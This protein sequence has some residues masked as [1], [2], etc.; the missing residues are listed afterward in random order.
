ME[1]P[2]EAAK[3]AAKAL[4]MKPEEI[5]EMLPKVKLYG[6]EGNFAQMGDGETPGTAIAPA[7]KI[8]VFFK[9]KGVNDSVVDVSELYESSYLK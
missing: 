6:A 3:L 1:N 2:E 9:E 5:L 4:E 8:A 7:E